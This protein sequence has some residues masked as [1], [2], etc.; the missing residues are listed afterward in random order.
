[1]GGRV[2]EPSSA[3]SPAAPSRVPQAARQPCAPPRAMPSG[4]ARSTPSPWGSCAF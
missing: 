1:M 4:S 2:S 3:R